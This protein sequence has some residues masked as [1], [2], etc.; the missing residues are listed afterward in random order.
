MISDAFLN[1][2]FYINI[3]I[4]IAFTKQILNLMYTGRTRV[5]NAISDVPAKCD[6]IS[7][8]PNNHSFTFMSAVTHYTKETK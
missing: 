6:Q 8:F 5:T 4:L 2:M 3:L 7:L 1:K